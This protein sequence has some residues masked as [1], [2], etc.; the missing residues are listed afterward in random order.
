VRYELADGTGGEGKHRGGEGLIRALELVEG[1]AHATLLADRQVLQPPGAQGGA[2][3]VCGRHSL[4]RDG[5]EKKIPAKVSLPLH[6]GDVLTIQTP[7]GGGYGDEGIAASAAH[8]E[9]LDESA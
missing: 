7:G 2:P 5:H 6:P 8:L 1:S 3:G 9:N 4:T